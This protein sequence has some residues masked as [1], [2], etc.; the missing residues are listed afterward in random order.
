MGSSGIFPKAVSQLKGMEEFSD[1][2]MRGFIKHLDSCTSK[3]ALAS[4]PFPD[5]PAWAIRCLGKTPLP[6]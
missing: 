6:A 5:F 2:Q 1:V 4:L 3:D